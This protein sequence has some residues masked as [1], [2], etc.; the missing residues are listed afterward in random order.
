MNVDFEVTL[1][2]PIHI[3]DSSTAIPTKYCFNP[4]LHTVIV[5]KHIMASY[6]LDNVG[7]NHCPSKL[8]FLSEGK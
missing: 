1:K 3:E 5:M 4:W 7:Q 6:S 2:D 8:Y